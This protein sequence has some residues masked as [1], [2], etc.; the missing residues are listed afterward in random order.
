MR[1]ER[2]K[3]EEKKKKKMLEAQDPEWSP[4]DDHTKNKR[5]KIP[6]CH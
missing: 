4:S 3:R 1:K 2:K 6:C 5:K